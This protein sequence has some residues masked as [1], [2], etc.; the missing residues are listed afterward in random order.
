MNIVPNVTHLLLFGEHNRNVV[1]SKPQR[2][3]HVEIEVI[4]PC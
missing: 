2:A 4:I 3:S 1:S